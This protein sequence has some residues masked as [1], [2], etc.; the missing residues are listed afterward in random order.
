M[1]SERG[2]RVEFDRYV[3]EKKK[4][5]MRMFAEN[6]EFTTGAGI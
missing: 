6:G 4:E 1:E 3:E 5:I 2:I